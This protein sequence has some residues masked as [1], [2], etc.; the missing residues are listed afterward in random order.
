MFTDTGKYPVNETFYSWQGEGMHLGRAAFFI[1]LH[2]CPVHCSWCDSA[3]TWNAGSAASAAARHELASELAA[4]A[5]ATRAEL[6]VITGGEPAIHDLAPL[7]T[8]LRQTG[9]PVHLE[10]CGAFPLS[11][12][13]DWVTL[14]PKRAAAPLPEN[15]DLADE[16]KLI[17]ET[18]EDLVHWTAFLPRLFHHKPNAPAQSVASLPGET[19]ELQAAQQ[20]G[21]FKRLKAVWLHPEWSQSTAPAVL[22]AISGW[23]RGHGAPFRAGWQVHKCYNAE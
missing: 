13:F 5:K 15:L 11:G 3:Q 22:E 12:D 7:T 21:C 18:P 8:A 10:T 20:A 4:R 17:I 19:D 1:R 2:G 16:I 14:S 23:V 6:V 9:M